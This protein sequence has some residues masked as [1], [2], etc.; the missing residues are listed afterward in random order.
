MVGSA[1]CGSSQNI[2]QLIA[3]RVIQGFGA[4]MIIGL[5]FAILGDVFTPAERGRWAGLMSA[6]FASASVLGPLIGGTLTDHAHWRWVFYVNIPLGAVAL[7]VLYFGMPS[8]R[9]SR[10]DR[11]DVPG[12]VLLLALGGAAA[13]GLLLGGEPLRL[14]LAAGPRPLRLGRRRPCRLLLRRDSHRPAAPAAVPLPEPY[15]LRVWRQSPCSPA[16]R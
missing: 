9:P 8:F 2:E 16:S 13:A 7:T 14:D 1:L 4:G 3:F 6:V 12:A 11:F 10:H 15:L 5:A